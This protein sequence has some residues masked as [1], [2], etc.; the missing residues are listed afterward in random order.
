MAKFNFFYWRVPFVTPSALVVCAVLL[1]SCGKSA[2]PGN[3]EFL[4]DP[5]TEAIARMI[6]GAINTTG[7]VTPD[8]SSSCKVKSDFF[9]SEHFQCANSCDG[10]N[11]RSS[12]STSGLHQYSCGSENYEWSDGKFEGKSDFTGIQWVNGVKPVGIQKAEFRLQGRIQ[13]SIVGGKLDCQI[14]ATL[15]FSAERDL[16]GIELNCES[17]RCALEET[18]VNCQDLRE[19]LVVNLCEQ[20]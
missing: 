5:S 17:T 9:Q 13:N 12:C 4:E 7:T 1:A 20:L 18:P 10:S 15:N 6:I 2:L 3:E 16:P 19:F 11:Y 8:N 14:S